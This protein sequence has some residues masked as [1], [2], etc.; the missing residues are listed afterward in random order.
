M[1]GG[2]VAAVAEVVG[3][4]GGQAG[5]E[6]AADGRPELVQ[7]DRVELDPACTKNGET[8]AMPTSIV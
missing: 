6:E 4:L 5:V 3:A 7:G 8:F 1:L 2:T